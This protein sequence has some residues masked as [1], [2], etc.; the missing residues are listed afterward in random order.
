MREAQ[1]NVTHLWFARLRLTDQVPEVSTF[2]QNRRR[3]FTD[4]AVYRGI[5]DAIVPPNL[6]RR[7]GPRR[8]RA[9]LYRLQ[10]SKYSHAMS[11]DAPVNRE[12][13]ALRA[14]A[15]LLVVV[16]HIP[17]LFV[18][19]VDRWTRFRTGMWVGVDIFF[20]IS[21]YVI[22]R[23]LMPRIQGKRGEPFWCEV[24]SFWVRR[25]YRIA[26]SAWLW[27]LVPLAIG[28]SFKYVDAAQLTGKNISDV[29]SVLFHVKNIQDFDCAQRGGICG[30]FGIYWSLSLEEQFY[31]L[32]PFVVLVARRRIVPVIGVLI[33]VQFF[34]WR[35]QWGTLPAFLRTDALLFGVLIA[36]FERSPIYRLVEPKF[37]DSW[38]R[39]PLAIAL[40]FGTV[41]FARYEITWFYTGIIAMI[42]AII[43][44][45]CSYDRGYF[46]GKSPIRTLLEWIGER[47]F[48]IYLIHMPAYWMTREIWERRV[49]GV[50][51]TSTYTLRF[52]LTALVLICVLADL[53]FRFVETP[54]R[55]KGKRQAAAI[56]NRFLPLDA[57][58]APSDQSVVAKTADL[59]IKGS[60]KTT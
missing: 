13:Q 58:S 47:S 52:A 53:N 32:F 16:S 46:L 7:D 43:I 25:F 35:P 40:V 45:I 14:I 1:V 28:L 38:V 51:V 20:A 23:G 17:A 6:V 48:A 18:W 39:Y 34:L 50:P 54:L 8:L 57:D 2:S 37:A 9:I 33:L 31:L 10:I 29:V 3:R 11:T 44:W 41:A 19:D 5:F 49:H 26:P 59:G 27:L 22:A 55:R 42:A 24:F 56:R 12:L 15:V 60:A 30:D 36:I 4:T 21:G